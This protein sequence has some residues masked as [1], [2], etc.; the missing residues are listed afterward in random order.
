MGEDFTT[1][2]RTTYEP[3]EVIAV[4]YDDK[5]NEV[6][7]NFLITANRDETIITTKVDKVKLHYNGNDFSFIEINVTDGNGIIKLLP[8]RTINVTAIIFLLKWK[9]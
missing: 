8:E 9:V 3:G 2:Y 6:S 4:G 1:R 5:G 7:I